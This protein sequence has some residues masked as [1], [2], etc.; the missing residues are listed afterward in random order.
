MTHEEVHE[1]KQRLVHEILRTRRELN[2][3]Q[4]N[5]EAACGVKQP[6]IAR[7]E[8]GLTDPQLTTILK[9]LEPLGKT[10][11]IVPIDDKNA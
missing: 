1:R 6:V 11:A 10:L 2:I 8:I 4:K 5:I 9:V 7:M 3:T